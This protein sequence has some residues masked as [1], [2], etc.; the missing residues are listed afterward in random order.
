MSVSM[1]MS[2]VWRGAR[3]LQR[4]GLGPGPGKGP[5]RRAG[6]GVHIEPQYR[7]YPELTKSQVLQSEILSGFMWFWIFW[8]MWHN[9]DAVTGHF[10]YPDPSKWT[11]EEL[12]IPPIDEE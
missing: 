9:P 1:S 7:Q 5:V 12:G 2:L 4:R 3:L 10:Q 6:G 8:H 11:D